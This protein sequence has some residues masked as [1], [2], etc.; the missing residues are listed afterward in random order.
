MLANLDTGIYI[1]IYLSVCLSVAMCMSV[2]QSNE[3]ISTCT[4]V[5][6]PY[7]TIFGGVIAFKPNE[8]RAI[9]G[10]SNQYFGWGGEDDDLFHR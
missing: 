6:V 5:R 2:C 10:F 3:I 7:T 9:N 4:Y 1:S 8:W